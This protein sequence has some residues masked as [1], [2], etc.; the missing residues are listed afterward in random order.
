MKRNITVATVFSIGLTLTLLPWTLLWANV[1][2]PESNKL[3]VTLMIVGGLGVCALTVFLDNRFFKRCTSLGLSQKDI[4][5]ELMAKIEFNKDIY[6]LLGAIT[7]E[8]EVLPFPEW[9][10]L[11]ELD[12]REKRKHRVNSTGVRVRKWMREHPEEVEY[13][14]KKRLSKEEV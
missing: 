1:F 12:R 11:K 4:E 6:R 13:V 5:G 7:E 14:R 9:D 8:G 10:L 2:Q 3:L